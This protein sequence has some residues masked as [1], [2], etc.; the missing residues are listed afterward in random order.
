MQVGNVFRFVPDISSAKG[1]ASDIL[2]AVPVVDSQS[3]EGVVTELS[4]VQGRI[5]FENVHFRYPRCPGVPVL[6]GLN[7]SVEKGT[8]VAL[9][10]ASGCGKSTTI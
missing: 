8:Y 6:R 7:L 3:S 10:G 2:T 9:V 1:A 4:A 5:R